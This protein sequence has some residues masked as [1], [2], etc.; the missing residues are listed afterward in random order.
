M[1]QV[2][3]EKMEFDVVIVGAGP[4]GLS[5]SI[6]LMQ[7]AQ[8]N[9]QTLSVCVVEKGSEVGAHIL[10]GN[11]FEPHALNELI[12]D[13]KEKG[14]PVSVL[15]KQDNF[16]FLTKNKHFKLPTP[17]QMNNHG[18]Y[19]ISLGNLCR[20]L[21]EQA[22]NLGVQIFP[23][24]PAAEVIIEN[25][26]VCGVITGDFGIGKNGE[27]KESYQAGMELRAKY[28]LLGEGCRGHLTKRLEQ[29]FNLREG[30]QPQ[31]YGIGLK[32][33]WKIKPENH[34][35]GKIVHTIGWP[36]DSRTYG[37][38]FLYHAEDNQVFIGYVV[39]LDYKNP[40][41]NPFKEFQRYKT[42]PFIS[43]TLEGGKR[44]SY[45][46]RAINEGGLQS[47]PKLTFSGGAI[48]GCAAGFLNVPKIKG[49]HTAMKSGMLAAET[50]YEAITQNKDNLGAYEDKIKNSWIYQEL[51]KVRNIR[52]SFR[53]GM[54]FGLIYS[55]IDT[56]I[57]RGRAPWTFIHHKDNECTKR[58]DK[59]KPI[60]YPKP[61]NVISFDLLSS[62]YLSGTFHEEDQPAHLKLTDSTIPV[63]NNLKL[64]DGPE[65]K[66]CPAGVYEF[67][68]DEAG[69][70][71]L[72]INAQNCVHCKT[73]DIKDNKQN[74][75]WVTPEGGG[76]PN[77]PN[78]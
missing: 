50:A 71:K 8:A 23:G 14:A 12:P 53:L 73:C 2:V 55:A 30:K 13:W 64:F 68:K 47:I 66:F 40:Y 29:K 27:K 72:Q 11:V 49:S 31:T 75:N 62:V 26:R 16:V 21:A 39:G 3:R 4:A 69:N 58:K 24:F 57:L 60:E 18:N 38:S 59:Y 36:V 56:Y 77:Y 19:I 51:Y 20:W 17:P 5:A 61:D 28:T 76:G 9:N 44:I 45:G 65:S 52:P 48:I 42:H 34:Q 6:K 46:A 37:G 74:I 22:T 33:I 43:K 78:M 10:S 41:I 63:E 7:L 1:E 67:I 70:D 54:I 25:D 15:A 35:Q 32:E